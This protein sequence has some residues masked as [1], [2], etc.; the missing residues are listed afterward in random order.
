MTR[1]INRRERAIRLAGGRPVPSGTFQAW[2]EASQEDRDRWEAQNSETHSGAD[3]DPGRGLDE[4]AL[5]GLINGAPSV[6]SGDDHHVVL[7]IRC[8]ECGS[9]I[10]HVVPGFQLAPISELV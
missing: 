4:L 8:A 7:D 10:A 3:V 5:H 1:K 6:I 2:W 9:V